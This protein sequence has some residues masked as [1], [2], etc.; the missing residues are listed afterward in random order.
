[1]S[2]TKRTPRINPRNAKNAVAVAKV[3]GPAVAPVL[4]P[5]AA[6]AAATLR[7]LKDNRRAHKLGIPVDDLAKFS[8]KGGALHARIAGLAE[9]LQELK[10]R[11]KDTEF[12]AETSDTLAKLTSAVR[13]AERM[14]TA[15]RRAV[16]KAVATELD[17]LEQRLL[18]KLGI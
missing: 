5:F 16:H 1:M 4:L 2:A 15:K 7:S 8:G 13:A 6:K 10:D 14:P 18:H 17:H 11:G 3:I 9:V 12:V